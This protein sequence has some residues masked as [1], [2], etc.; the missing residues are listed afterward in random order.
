MKEAE[1]EKARD[2]SKSEMAVDDSY[3][4]SIEDRS[5]ALDSNSDCSP[6]RG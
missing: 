2:N 1:E 6:I 3:N 4:D 5:S